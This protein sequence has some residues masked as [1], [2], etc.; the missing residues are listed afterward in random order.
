MLLNVCSK[1]NWSK[2]DQ[3]SEGFDAFRQMLMQVTEA[4]STGENEDKTMDYLEKQLIEAFERTIDRSEQRNQ[5]FYALREFNQTDDLV[6]KNLAK[7]FAPL[8]RSL[9]KAAN[10]G[11]YIEADYL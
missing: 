8:A 4:D 7:N 6:D 3:Q 2:I 1:L 5:D 9:T 11:V 10:S